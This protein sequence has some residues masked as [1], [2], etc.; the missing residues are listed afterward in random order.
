MGRNGSR[1]KRLRA[2]KDYPSIN[3]VASFSYEGVHQISFSREVPDG[4]DCPVCVQDPGMDGAYMHIDRGDV[5]GVRQC[6]ESA[7]DS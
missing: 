3:M 5:C 7:G 1:G 2:S 6:F 4:S